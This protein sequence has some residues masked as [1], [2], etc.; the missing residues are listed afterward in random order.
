ML[1]FIVPLK[2]KEKAF[3]WEKV[4]RLLERT[5]RSIC[6]QVC[7][8]FRAIVVCSE[9]PKIDF[10]HPH[11]NYLE[12]DFPYPD[13]QPSHLARARTDKGR[14]ILA[15]L[16]AA[17]SFT[18]THTMVVDAD[19]CVSKNL[20]GFVAKNPC[21]NGWYIRSGYKYLENDSWIYLKRWNF[22]QISGS[23]LLLRYD[24]NDLPDNPEYN[25]GYGYYK[26]YIDHEKVKDVLAQKKNPIKPLPF[27]GAVYI[28]GTGEN[29][30]RNELNL[31]FNFLD[32]RKLTTRICD[33]FGLSK[34]A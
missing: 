3:S 12:A 30:S 28:I 2:R 16:K 1:V 24:L 6:N 9:R 34:I 11:I 32:R 29:L 22:Y 7:T 26:F 25:R 8:S 31:R 5:L 23:G 27:P 33:E 13:N 4:S 18:P 19:D 20:A 10:S 21:A 14:R 15:G 17:K